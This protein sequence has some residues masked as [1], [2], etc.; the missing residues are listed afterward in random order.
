[1]TNIQAA[2]GGRDVMLA[3]Y[4]NAA[5]STLVVAAW[6]L[7]ADVFFDT[8][9]N[10]NVVHNANGVDWYY[11]SGWSQGFVA[12]GTGVNKN[13]CDVASVDPTRRLCFHTSAGNIQG[14][15]RCGAT[16]AL[17]ANAAWTRVFYRRA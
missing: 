14:G 11:N 1:M 7:R 6:A 16:T 17:N 3:C 8:G 4:N 15:Y 13:S 5:P 10:S 2:C 12:Q 9:V